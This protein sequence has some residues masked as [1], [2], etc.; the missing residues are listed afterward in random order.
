MPILLADAKKLSQDK[1]TNQ[2]IDEFIKSPV[3]EKMPFDDT[4]TS[5]GG[6]STTLTYVYNRIT[7]QPTAGTRA[8]NAEYAAQETKTTQQTVN[9]KVMGG[10]Y[11]VD[12]VIANNEKKVV[13][14]VIFQTEQKSKATKAV[15]HDLLINGDSA[16]DPTQFD[17]IDKVVTGSSTEFVPAA[18]IAVETAANIASN[19]G[20]F[21]FYLRKLIGKMDGAP[22]ALLMNEDMYAIFQAIADKVPNIKFERNQLGDEVGYYGSAQLVKMGEK[23]GTTDPIIATSAGGETAIYAVR[24]GMDGVHGVSP[25]GSPIVKNFLPDFSTPGAVKKGEVEFVGAVAVKTTRSVGVLRK[26]KVA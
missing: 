14:H 8:I 21:L 24:I 12:R 7:T 17:G 18:A 6:N 20:T 2:V 3:M 13:N 23:A 25:E 26:I 10:S 11:E 5:Q 16:V 9:L 19:Y 22:T 1:L 4:A 15:F